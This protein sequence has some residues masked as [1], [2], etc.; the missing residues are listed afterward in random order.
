[1][2][3]DAGVI[4]S[5][6]VIDED[7]G[8]LIWTGAITT[9]QGY[10]NANVGGRTVLVHRLIFELLVG[11][12][13]EGHQIDHLCR[14][15][16]CINVE[17]LEPVTQRENILRGTSPSAVHARQTEC[18]RGHDLGPGGDVAID[19]RGSRRCRVCTRIRRGYE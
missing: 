10:A 11:P 3:A 17:H 7:T 15:R 16:A 12:I 6:V 14:V 9:P 19:P 13:P 2:K 1:M 5:R 18:I 8:C 4:L